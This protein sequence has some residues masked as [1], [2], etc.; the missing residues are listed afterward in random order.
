MR[1]QEKILE[2][3]KKPPVSISNFLNTRESKIRAD[4]IQ[5]FFSITHRLSLLRLFLMDG[6]EDENC[7]YFIKL[8]NHSFL[9]SLPSL[10]FLFP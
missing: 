5:F 4:V 1:R 8:T 2:L 7:V 3:P 6:R 10:F 9:L